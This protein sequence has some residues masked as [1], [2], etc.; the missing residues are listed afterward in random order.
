MALIQRWLLTACSCALTRHT[1]F[2]PACTSLAAKELVHSVPVNRVSSNA[3]GQD[4]NTSAESVL[5][6][7]SPR[8]DRGVRTKNDQIEAHPG[9]PTHERSAIK[10]HNRSRSV[11]TIKPYC[12]ILGRRGFPLRWLE[13]EE[14][15][16]RGVGF[17]DGYRA[18]V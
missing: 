13:Q 3:R 6:L 1:G 8:P 16:S 4:N 9:P 14:E 7:S 18:A 17:V 2:W 11:L 12:K 10:M 15:A 5:E